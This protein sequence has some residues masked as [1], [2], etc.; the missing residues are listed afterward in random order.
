MQKLLVGLCVGVNSPSSFFILVGDVDSICICDNVD[1]HVLTKVILY[2]TP[3]F[4]VIRL[5][6]EHLGDVKI[7]ILVAVCAVLL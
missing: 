7:G 6:L 4:L 3:Y 1:V 5:L 2:L